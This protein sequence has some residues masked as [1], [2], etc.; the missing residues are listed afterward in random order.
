MRL[1][2]AE[3]PLPRRVQYSS[4][5]LSQGLEFPRYSFDALSVQNANELRLLWETSGSALAYGVSE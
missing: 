4:T 5:Q 1:A 2:Y 3:Q